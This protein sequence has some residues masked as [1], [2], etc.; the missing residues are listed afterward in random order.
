MPFDQLPGSRRDR[1]VGILST[2]PPQRCGLATF[3]ASL[4]LELV[5]AGDD[6]TVVAIDDGRGDGSLRSKAHYELIN[7]L[8]TSI[9][10]AAKVLSR[11]DVA[12]VQHEYGIYGGVDGDEVLD[13]LEQLEVPA[14]VVL[15]TVP[16]HPTANQQRILEAIC[17]QAAAVVVMTNAARARLTDNYAVDGERVTMIPH[18]AWSLPAARGADRSRVTDHPRLLTWGLLGPGKG[19]EHVIRALTLIDDLRPRVHYSVAGAT[20]PKVFARDGDHYRLSL[21]RT[22][23]AT[24]VAG[25]IHFDDSYR[26]SA[27][28]MRFVRSASLVVLPY[29]SPDQV[30]SGVLVDAIAAGRPVIATAFPHAVELLSDGAGII[31]PHREPVALASAIR[32]ALCE[33]GL[34]E[35]MTTRARQLA[36]SLGWPTVAAQYQALTD[37]VTSAAVAVAT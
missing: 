37:A 15:H 13:V 16:A 28:L 19:I 18:G 1:R 4:E 17:E 25:S 14:I 2:Y 36:P 20:H 3:A 31:V 11:G 21:I 30:T 7:G 5:D 26:D 29:D 32:T 12:I 8:P 9:R 10:D 24:G 35:A 23:W 6:V 34:L 27:A 22:A 33:P